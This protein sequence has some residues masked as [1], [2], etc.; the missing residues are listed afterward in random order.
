MRIEDL[1]KEKNKIVVIIGQQ[2]DTEKFGLEATTI[3]HYEK[4]TDFMEVLALEQKRDQ[5]FQ[6]DKKG[7]IIFNHAKDEHFK[8]DIILTLK[9][10]YDSWKLEGWY[11]G[12][13]KNGEIEIKKLET[14]S[15]EEFKKLQEESY[16][17]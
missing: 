8:K 15:Q 12:T 10:M 3:M 4:Y 14:I 11:Y 9:L 1:L 13:Y 16:K 5:V 6:E 17:D 2:I 7:I